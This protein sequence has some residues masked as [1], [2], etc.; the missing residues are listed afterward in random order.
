MFLNQLGTLSYN[1][2]SFDGSSKITAQIEM[3][4]DEAQRTIIYQRQT[5]T[6]EATVA[7]TDTGADMDDIKRRLGEQGRTLR[8]IQ[9]GFADNLIVGPDGVPDLKFGPVPRIISWQPIGANRAC[10]I[11]WEV[12]VH[13]PYCDNT[14]ARRSG[15]LA[16]NYE[17][18]F[19][20]RKGHT[21]RTIT[22]YLEI[23]Q[24]RLGRRAPDCA[25]LYRKL[26]NPIAPDGFDRQH[27]WTTSKDKCR[28]DF[29]IVDTQI[30][31]KFAFP[32]GVSEASGRHRSSW[33][34]NNRGA[35]RLRNSINMDLEMVPGVSQSQAWA[36]FGNIVS[37]RI[38]HAKK[39]GLPVLLDELSVE[40]DIWG[41]ASSFSVGWQIL[42]SCAGCLPQHSGLWQPIGT[43]WT[44]W[45]VSMSSIFDNRGVAQLGVG[46]GDAIIDLCGDAG[47]TMTLD[48]R[49]YTPDEP[50][51]KYAPLYKNEIPPPQYS[52]LKF[53]NAIIPA[54]SRPVQRQA[55]LQ[56]TESAAE[57]AGDDLAGRAPFAFG[58]TGGTSDEIQEGGRSRYEVTMVGTATR[59]GYPVPRPSLESIGK[60]STTETSCKMAQT[61][62]GNWF[63]LPIYSAVWTAKYVVGNSPGQMK[64]QANPKE[65]VDKN[66]KAICKC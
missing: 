63:G 26:V 53:D 17:A 47:A 16:F 14:A 24:T 38:N 41:R 33:S 66:G 28:L 8:V 49:N 58:P 13:L 11:V 36:I 37:Q 52:Y 12:V 39:Q 3:V 64:A 32:V 29:T 10:E 34:R 9:R 61:V 55:Y 19:A 56:S 59:A 27:N 42:K 7:D 31:S 50:K 22:G 65:E 4:Q 45:R 48:S 44:R 2:Y 6:I 57:L 46:A 51:P 60:Q 40:E 35:T 18:N 20:I 43:D 1:G 30:V 62:V 5:F 54:R 15:L 23:G 25:D 21:V